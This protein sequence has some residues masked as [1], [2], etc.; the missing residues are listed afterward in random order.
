MRGTLILILLFKEILHFLQVRGTFK[1]LRWGGTSFKIF[2]LV[3]S[4]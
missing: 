2:C 4:K 3:E 1:Y